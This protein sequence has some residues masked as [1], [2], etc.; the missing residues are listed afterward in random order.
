[1]KRR[2]GLLAD[3]CS[4][5][6]AL[7]ILMTVALAGAGTTT[8]A[9][10]SSCTATLSAAATWG[11]RFNLHVAV[12]GSDTWTVTLGL[13]PR[14]S[15]QNSWNAKVT[16]S[17]STVTA[18]PSGAGNNFGV[19]IMNGGGSNTDWP[20]VSCTVPGTTTPPTTP[21]PTTPPPSG[22][23]AKPHVILSTDM[24]PVKNGIPGGEAGPANQ[25]SDL[26]DTQTLVRFLS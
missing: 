4:G 20:T 7:V 12:T 25:K 11:D 22:T 19:T 6:T 8:A 15:L 26:D 10:A 3:V 9:A 18:T 14:Q 1:M 2:H 21:P 23:E 16:A 5:I 13:K 17:G 24:P